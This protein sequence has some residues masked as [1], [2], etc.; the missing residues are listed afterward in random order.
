MECWTDSNS[1]RI[2]PVTWSYM[3]L[4]GETNDVSNFSQSPLMRYFPYRAFCYAETGF[5]FS[6]SSFNSSTKGLLEI[7]L[8]LYTELTVPQVSDCCPLGR[9]VLR[10]D[11]RPWF[12]NTFGCIL[13]S[14]WLSKGQVID[15]IIVRS[16]L[17]FPR[18]SHL[19]R[20]QSD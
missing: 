4:S 13:P 5:D 18:V 9:L 6:S 3:T 2:W 11:S 19:V 14:L 7:R 16:Y 20:S 15:M 10:L 17:N 8:Y 12:L 1:D